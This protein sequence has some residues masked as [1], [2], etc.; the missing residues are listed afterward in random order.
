MTL[1]RSLPRALRGEFEEIFG[2]S[3]AEVTIRQKGRG[4]PA[5]HLARTYGSEIDFAYG[6]YDPHTR[7]GREVLGHEL[8]HVLQQRHGR[9][10]DTDPHALEL[11]AVE[12][13]RRAG[14]GEPVRLPGRTDPRPHRAVQHYTVIAA[15][16]FA[17]QGIAVV[18]PQSHAPVQNQDSFIG[19]TK[20]AVG[21]AASSFL[22]AGGAVNTVSANPA[23]VALRFSQNRRLAVEDADLTNRQPKVLYATMAMINASN[24][25]LTLIG[26]P[27]RLLPDAP[28][29]NQQTVTA[30]GNQLFRV[31]PQNLGNATSGLTMD[32]AQSCD[33]LISQVLVSVLPPPQP[34][35]DGN[36]AVPPH[37]MV[38]YHAA[39]AALPGAP[40]PVLDDTTPVTRHTTARQI[41]AAFGAATLAP[42]AAFTANLR[43]FGLNQ[44][45]NPGVGEGFVICT[46]MSGVPGSSLVL[47]NN[48]PSQ[49]DF[50]T[51]IGGANPVVMS[52]LTWGSHWGTV[53]ARDGSDVI[54]LENYARKTED[55]LA[56]NDTRYYFQMYQTDPAAPA[57]GLTWH[58]SWADPPMIA[59]P[60]PVPAVPPPHLAPT[61]RPAS[62]GQRGFVNPITMRVAPLPDRWDA[63]A[64]AMHGGVT[65]DSVQDH[66]GNIAATPTAEAEVRE[67]LK[68][69]YLANARIA[70]HTH[71]TNARLTL[72]IHALTAV[73]AGQRFQENMQAADRTLARIIALRDMV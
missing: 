67:I 62:P 44:Y 33:A 5:Q 52:N 6:G 7:Q 3:F 2:A 19:Q 65:P 22:T 41:G 61:H 23:A 26:S 24:A 28:G 63:R 37:L 38:E 72:W 47:G 51:L 30:G 57:G 48:P 4:E 46:L 1:A 32:A 66:H 35:F 14:L 21:G 16:N 55:A 31:T 64:T 10:A 45:A 49:T 54:T 27:I 43:S 42:T 20:G 12:A 56:G 71:E 40:L 39:R 18:N 73:I 70:A 69:L 58:Q 50:H 25:R 36:P 9:T 60:A 13:G 34:R 17:A 8:A 29:P 68:G 15:A 11:E 59:Y 53:I